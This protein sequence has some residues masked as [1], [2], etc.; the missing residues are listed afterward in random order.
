M[1]CVKKIF[2][3]VS[4][5]TLHASLTFCSKVQN[6]QCHLG[7]GTGEGEKT[8]WP[9]TWISSG[10]IKPPGELQTWKWDRGP[11]IAS[12]LI[13]IWAESE[14]IASHQHLTLGQGPTEN[15]ISIKWA[16]SAPQ[17]Q[18]IQIFLNT[19]LISNVFGDRNLRK[20]EF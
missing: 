4:K 5:H 6:S 11:F 14:V 17:P 15:K 18:P 19:I 13:K 9:W 3:W 12:L 10:T 1:I 8:R 2:L 20:T 7:T 16:C